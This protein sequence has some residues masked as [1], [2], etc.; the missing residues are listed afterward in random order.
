MRLRLVLAAAPLA[1]TLAPPG[2]WC[3][4]NEAPAPPARVVA[5]EAPPPAPGDA[6]ETAPTGASWADFPAATEATAP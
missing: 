6:A 1:A 3:V 4:T 2:L 5:V